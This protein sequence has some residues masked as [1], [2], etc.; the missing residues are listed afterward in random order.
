LVEIMVV[1]V[2]IAML[3]GV[4]TISVRGYMTAGSQSTTKAEIA[5]ICQ[6]LDTYY[7]LH[8]RYPDTEEGIEALTQSTPKMPEPPL[9]R[10]PVDAWGQP[11]TYLN[12]G[13]DTPYEVISFGADG[14]EGGEGADADISSAELEE[15]AI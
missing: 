13:R 14:R 6:A 4:A 3:A 7:S 11:Y 8:N 12:P 9:A 5:T 1:L 10:V 15:G 2:I